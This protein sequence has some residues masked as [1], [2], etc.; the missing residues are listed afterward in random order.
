MAGPAIRYW[1]LAK[2]LSNSHSVTLK[3][4]NL[5]TL[6][7][8]QFQVVCSKDRIKLNQFDILITQLIDPKT[9]LLAKQN[10][11]RLIYDAYDPE[12][13]EHLEIFK[14][15][16]MG[17]RKFLNE[18]IINTINFSLEM[19]DG[20]IC[21][22]EKQRE[23]WTGCMLSLKKI[24]PQFYDK[25]TALNKLI[26]IVP[27]GISSEAPVKSKDGFRKLFNLKPSDKLL[28]WGG[29]IW[30]WFD[31]LTLITAVKELSKRRTDIKLIFMGIIHPNAAT[32]PAMSMAYE[33]KN[34]TKTFGLENKFVFFN[35]NWIPY[36]ERENYLLD[37]DIGVSTHFEHLETRF[38]FRTR[39][40]DYIWAGLPIIATSGDTLSEFIEKHS[41]GY[42]VKPNNSLE[43]AE[44]IEKMV[45]QPDILKKMKS[46]IEQVKSQFYWE[47]VVKPIEDMICVLMDQRAQLTLQ[48]IK[49]ISKCAWNKVGPYALIQRTKLMLNNL[50][51]S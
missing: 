28:I 21:A 8:N 26:G 29:G 34:L 10:G 22:N 40:L 3:I 36:S 33:A 48:D 32:L 47:N 50:L 49:K 19:A 4:P 13:L 17:T 18:K 2:A 12:P 43:L 1:E 38:S 35:E 44:A 24:T 37:A 7:S 30:N 20:L 9:A 42:T 11:V 46:N 25:D 27:F 14:S 39:L 31:P 15:Y 45:D 16:Q 51:N 5:D 41:I 23:L 6:S